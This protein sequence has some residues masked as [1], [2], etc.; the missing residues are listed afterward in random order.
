MNDLINVCHKN[1]P[2]RRMTA[3]DVRRNVAEV[4]KVI[5]ACILF[6]AIVCIEGIVEYLI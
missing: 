5:V 4:G 6:V 2:R 3:S 1:Y